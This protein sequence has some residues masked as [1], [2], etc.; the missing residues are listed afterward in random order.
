MGAAGFEMGRGTLVLLETL[1]AVRN[2]QW[3]LHRIPEPSV[4]LFLVF[5]VFGTLVVIGFAML[6]GSGQVNVTPQVQADHVQA[7]QHWRLKS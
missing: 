5:A 7:D 3:L 6:D 1:M 2:I 4:R